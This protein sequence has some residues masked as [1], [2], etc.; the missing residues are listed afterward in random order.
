MDKQKFATYAPNI[1]TLANMLLGLTAILVLTTPEHPH[2]PF[3]V[4]ACILLG[5]VADYFDGYIARKFN[6][7]TD[8]GKQLD[9]FADLITFGIAPISLVNYVFACE[10]HSFLVFLSL[11]FPIAGMYRLARYNLSEFSGHYTGLPITPSGVTL[12]VYSIICA[13]WA[14]YRQSNIGTIVTIVLIVLLAVMMVSKVKIRR[15]G[16]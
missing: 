15:I 14:E 1:L 9:S 6:A 3:I 11:V 7:V 4:A 8:M 10:T 2:K 13:L 5:A 12:A 16:N